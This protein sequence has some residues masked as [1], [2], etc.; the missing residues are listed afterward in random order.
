MID[1]SRGEALNSHSHVEEKMKKLY[2]PMQVSIATYLGGP[3]A[4]IYFL[5]VNFDALGKKEFANKTLFFG[6][7][8]AIV[9]ISVIPIITQY[10]SSSI[11]PLFYLFPVMYVVHKY[12]MSKMDIIESKEYEFRSNWTVCGMAILW[13]VTYLILAVIVL[14]VLQSV[15]IVQSE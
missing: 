5:K 6:S 15:G 7:L 14:Q 1:V 12:Q 10:A 13:M 11:I 4:A 2:S 9:L 3:L 8:I